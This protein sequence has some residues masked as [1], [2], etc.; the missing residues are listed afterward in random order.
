MYTFSF[1][2]GDIMKSVKCIHSATR[3]LVWEA[4]GFWVLRQV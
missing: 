4:Y 1:I 3:L 2:V